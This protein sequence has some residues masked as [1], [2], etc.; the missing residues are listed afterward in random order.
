[1]ITTKQIGDSYEYFVLN[2]IKHQYD[3]VWHW[4]KLPEQILYDLNI[5]RN[6]DIFSKYRY[7]IGADLVAIKDDKYYFIQCKNFSET[8][9]MEHLAGFYFLLHEYNLNG[10]L[11]Y[12]GKL[13]QRVKDLS[14]KKVQFINLPF[15]NQTII[16][17]T[18]K[19]DKLIPKEY[20]L[21]AYEQLK[22]YNKC[23][24]S[25][26][27]GMGKTYTASM[28]ANHYD[29]IVIMAPLRYLAQQLLIN[30]SN[31]LD[32]QYNP[33][34][35]S[36]DG[37]RDINQIKSYIKNKNIFSCTY[38]STDIMVQLIDQLD[39][40]YLIIDQFHNLSSNDI[41]NDNSNINL[42][43]ISTNKHLYLSATPIKEFICDYK[44]EYSWKDA[45]KNKYICDFDIVIHENNQDLYKFSY[46]LK[47]LCSDNLDIKLIAKAYFML[48]GMMYFGNRKCI[49]YM[50]CIEKANKMYDILY[51]MSKLLNVEIDSWIITCN[52]AKTKRANYLYNF[53]KGT[54]GKNSNKLCV[55]INVHI[56]D[57]GIDIPECDSV[58]ITQPNN[59]IINIV[60]R[61]CRANRITENKTKCQIFLWCNKNKTNKILE[62]LSNNTNG[63]ID[64]KVI[65]LRINNTNLTHKK[66]LIIKNN[67]NN[68]IQNYDE[69]LYDH[70]V[71]K[72]KDIPTEFIKFYINNVTSLGYVVDLEKLTKWLE[73]K[74]ENLKRLLENNFKEDEDYTIEKKEY[75]FKNGKGCNNKKNIMLTYKCSKILCMM[76]KTKKAD[77]FRNFYVELEKLAI[78][79]KQN[80]I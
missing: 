13:S 34:L 69:N 27:C 17:N 40:V 2:E 41:N 18:D 39:N 45:I 3:Q 58:F 66:V 15:N 38:D 53:A 70:L 28:L 19:N 46:L 9:L 67:L 12:N 59:N 7:D 43:M 31:Y 4:S 11:Y 79:Y 65:K 50:T 25:L 29:N 54:C 35:V 77:I 68:S 32:N 76:S 73:I 61:M 8:I 26:P 6:Y 72:A 23:I 71:E 5:I 52:T 16:T 1:M 44:Y 80:L 36:M 20:Q 49:C 51:W 48:K 62:Y 57:E 64:N 14:T 56:L 22:N 21:E 30:M 78:V 60:Q 33:I 63:I 42:I 74:K 55:M 10:I 47:Q 75:G 24:L 37:S